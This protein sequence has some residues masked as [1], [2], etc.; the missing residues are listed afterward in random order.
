MGAAYFIVLDNKQPGFDTFVNGKAVTRE[1]DAI[2][3]I[4]KSLGLRDIHDFA[5]FAGMAEEFDI[6]PE[7]P[8]AQ[9]VW[10]PASEGVAWVAAIRSHIDSHASGVKNVE[11][12]KADLAEYQRVLEQA[13]SINAKWHFEMDI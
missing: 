12:V 8:A 5:S 9:E 1:M 2:S 13:A 3:E 6:D 10:F 7:L 4:A 11:A